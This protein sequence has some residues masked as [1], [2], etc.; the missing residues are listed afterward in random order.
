MS[1]KPQIF[2]NSHKLTQVFM[3]TIGREGRKQREFNPREGIQAGFNWK[4][5]LVIPFPWDFPMCL[6]PIL[7][8]I[9]LPSPWLSHKQPLQKGWIILR[10]F[11]ECL[12]SILGSRSPLSCLGL[13]SLCPTLKSARPVHPD[14][15]RSIKSLELPLIPDFRSPIRLSFESRLSSLPNQFPVIIREEHRELRLQ[16]ECAAG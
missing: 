6:I 3:E 14:P 9:P 12:D 13:F 11:W 8:P 7:H 4:E 1:W 5:I 10:N 15:E 16:M 2:Q